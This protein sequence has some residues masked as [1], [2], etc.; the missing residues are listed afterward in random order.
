[1][2][3]VFKRKENL[4]LK[5]LSIAF[6]LPSI[7]YAIRCEQTIGLLFLA[8]ASIPAGIR[9]MR[10]SHLISLG[11]LSFGLIT[12]PLG[13]GGLLGKIGN[14][15]TDAPAMIEIVGIGLITSGIL[16]IFEY[17][18][19]KKRSTYTMK[20]QLEVGIILIMVALTCFLWAEGVI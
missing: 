6:I 8:M 1:M 12:L 5:I 10:E 15:L 2:K 17:I 20:F 4:I 19:S 13:V 11:L 9:F 14:V 16:T 3:E 7:Y 18:V